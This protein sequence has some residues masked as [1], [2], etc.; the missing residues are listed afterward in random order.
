[1]MS[2]EHPRSRQFVADIVEEMERIR[3]FVADLDYQQFLEDDRTRYAVCYA[4]AVVGEAA[5]RIP[6]TVKARCPEV[7]W[8]GMAGMRDILAH[9][10]AA[11]EAFVLWETIT[12][13]LPIELPALRRLLNELES[14]E[15][16]NTP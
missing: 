4:F 13:R 7:D 3:R 6:D 15:P 5:K 11:V 12:E 9:Q 1:M 2:A 16:R 10:Y 8:R 14:G